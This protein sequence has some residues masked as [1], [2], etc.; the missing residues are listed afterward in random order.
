MSSFINLSA[1]YQFNRIELSDRN[2][3]L[4]AH[5]ARLR[6]LFMFSTKLSCSAFIQYNSSSDVIITNFRLR[7]NPREGN[8]LYLVYD[9]GLNL[10]RDREI[11]V[12]PVRSDRSILLKYS[13]TFNRSFGHHN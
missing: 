9:E 12:L 10:D 11:P 5:I 1:Y 6:A 8:D 7:Y 4:N 3:D 2:Q 13:Y